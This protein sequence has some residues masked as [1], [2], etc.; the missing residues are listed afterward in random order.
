MAPTRRLKQR[1]KANRLEDIIAP[2]FLLNIK[3]FPH[4]MGCWIWI[5]P[6]AASPGY[7]KFSI[8]HGTWGAHRVSWMIFRGPIPDKMWVLHKCDNRFCVNPDHLFLGT[9]KDNSQDMIRKGRYGGNRIYGKGERSTHFKIS[10]E[11][12][13]FI[14]STDLSSGVLAKMFEVSTVTINCIK[15]GAAR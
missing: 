11:S 6:M 4:P 13:K 8:C 7:G 15:R 5:G 9:P 12:V 2:A 10:D 14:R 1:F 3:K